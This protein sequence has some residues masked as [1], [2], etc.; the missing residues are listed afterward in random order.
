MFEVNW[1]FGQKQNNMHRFDEAIPLCFA[2]HYFVARKDSSLVR[3]RQHHLSF[4]AIFVIVAIM[5]IHKLPAAVWFEQIKGSA[6][7]KLLDY[8]VL[9]VVCC[10]SAN[11]A[12]QWGLERGTPDMKSAGSLTFGPEDVLFVGDTKSAAVFA[13]ATGDTTGDPSKSNI[14]VEDVVDKIGSLVGGNATIN[15]IAVSPATGNV[16]VSATANDKPALLKIDGAGKI[17]QLS[18]TDVLFAKAN[19]AGAPEDKVTGEGRRAKN[20]RKDAITD[21]AFFEGKL[22]ISGL[23]N[24]ST[25]SSVRELS[26]PFATADQ[27]VGVQIYHAA[28]GKEEDYA[29]MRTFVP[30]MIDGEPNLLAAYVCT[31]LVKIPMKELESAADRIK[32]TTVAELGNRNQPLDM[33]SYTKDGGNYL[34][35]SNSAR[36]VMKITTSGLSDNKGLTEPV[37]GG[38]AAGQSYDTVETMTGVIQ[39]DKLNDTHAVLLVEKDGHQNLRTVALP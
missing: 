3:S 35:L 26:F 34:L 9:A 19:L 29:A 4:C 31:P 38:G 30:L 16:F 2:K 5:W 10:A 13:I 8:V 6:M 24:A 33:F 23:R 12:D 32:G 27:G 15:D 17:T 37:R 25:A 21:L 20:N 28:H 7:R 36:G 18:M 11:A 22:L 1:K 39:M 14:N